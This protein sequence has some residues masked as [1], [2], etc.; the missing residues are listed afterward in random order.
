M[1]KLAITAVTMALLLA[2]QP[3]FADPLVGDVTRQRIGNFD[4]EIA[5]EPSPPQAGE[6][7]QIMLRIAGV[8]GDDLIDV[9]LQITIDK[10]G[11]TLQSIGPLVAPFGHYNYTFVFP[12]PGRYVFYADL[13]DYAYS[14]E[15]LTFTFFLNVP[16]PLDYIVPGI[17]AAAAVIVGAIVVLRRRRHG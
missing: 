2:F 15:V 8:N 3:A 14:G 17:G 16:G 6:P 4:F 13:R 7:A 9:P 10:D 5:T 12:D 1:L 11:Q